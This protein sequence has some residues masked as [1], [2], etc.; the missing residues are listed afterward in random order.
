MY[1]ERTL[2]NNQQY[3]QAQDKLDKIKLSILQ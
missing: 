1:K 3:K 2:K